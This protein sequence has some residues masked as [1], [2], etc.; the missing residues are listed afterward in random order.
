MFQSIRLARLGHGFQSGL[1]SGFQSSIRMMS[2]MNTTSINLINPIMLNS[3]IKP[4]INNITK[5]SIMTQIP[6]INKINKINPVNPLDK[7]KQES[8]LFEIK[9]QEQSDVSMQL[10]SVM[11]KR[12]Y[13]IKK[14]KFRK[15][16]KAQ[17]ELRRKLKK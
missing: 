14:H 2:S 1:K 11:R 17:R 16:R 7:S 15:R 12:R 8:N 3:M 13:K 6:S 4:A 10:D 9:D 5:Q